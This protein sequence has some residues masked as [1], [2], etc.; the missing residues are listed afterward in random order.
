MIDT[1]QW[2]FHL[3]AG[4]T[5]YLLVLPYAGILGDDPYTIEIEYSAI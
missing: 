5:W 2:G 4:S 3:E 1:A